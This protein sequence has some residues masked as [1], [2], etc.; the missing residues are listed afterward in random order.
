[1]GGHLTV[2]SQE[3]HGSTFSFVIPCNV[4]PKPDPSDDLEEARVNESMSDDYAECDSDACFS[5]QPSAKGSISTGV[6]S[7][8]RM[9]QL[10][11]GNTAIDEFD[12]LQVTS[13]SSR[14]SISMDSSCSVAD[15][16]EDPSENEWFTNETVNV[17]NKVFNGRGE[18]QR[19]NTNGLVMSRYQGPALCGSNSHTVE[20]TQNGHKASK[21][22]CNPLAKSISEERSSEDSNSGEKTHQCP[23]QLTKAICQPKILLVEDNKINIMVTQSMMKQI[24][25]A[26][27]VVNNGLEAIRAVQNRHYDLV[28][29]VILHVRI[30]MSKNF[31]CCLIKPNK[32][33]PSLQDVCMPVMD[34]L[35]ATRLIRSFEENGNWDALEEA[36]IELDNTYI[37]QGRSD[38]IASTLRRHIPIIAVCCIEYS[39]LPK[40]M[41]NS[42][43]I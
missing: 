6:G 29:M 14:E 42:I 17:D 39:Q 7:M 9:K 26:I 18:S 35:Q 20:S 32:F 31:R 21:E 1:M 16:A 28:L 43:L 25:H 36:G 8:P 22:N 30:L 13:A 33:F 27:D 41:K 34:G 40:P 3:N 24:G 5:F 12:D 15:T 2:T 37:S 11:S 10:S 38:H 19:G 4:S 23:P